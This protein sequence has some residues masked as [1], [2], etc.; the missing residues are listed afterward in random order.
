VG[1]FV[2]L[3]YRFATRTGIVKKIESVRIAVPPKGGIIAIQI[4]ADDCL[5]DAKLT[6]N[7]NNNEA[8]PGY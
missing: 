6:N 8:G 1:L 3:H 5:I 2:C 7:G 4:E